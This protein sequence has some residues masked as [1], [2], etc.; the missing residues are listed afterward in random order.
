[1]APVE[2][3]PMTIRRPT[4]TLERFVLAGYLCPD[5]REPAFTTGLDYGLGG[6]VLVDL[7]ALER[8]NVA[9]H[10]VLVV[11]KSSTGDSLYD[12]VV[13]RTLAAQPPDTVGRWLRRMSLYLRRHVL[14]SLVQGG[15]LVRRR[16][17][18]WHILPSTRYAAGDAELTA[19]VADELAMAL[20]L[21][22]AADYSTM[23]LIALLAACGVAP[24]DVPVLCRHPEV[25]VDHP[26][27]PEPRLENAYRDIFDAVT[28]CVRAAACLSL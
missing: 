12:N 17:R 1:L 9:D 25:V 19:S 16:G 3:M 26:D 18:A 28:D 11:A 13:A 23:H 22:S 21:P 24:R 10:H 8:V 7:V 14:P 5:G 6:A 20:V 2:W 4:P 15:Q 27:W